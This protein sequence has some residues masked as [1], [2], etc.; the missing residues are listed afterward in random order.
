MR[1][2]TTLGTVLG[3]LIVLAFVGFLAAATQSGTHTGAPAA[4]VEATA[5]GTPA[6]TVEVA[7]PVPTPT[8]LGGPLSP[9]AL[10]E[11][12]RLPAGTTIVACE[13]T[14][15]TYPPGTFMSGWDF[16]T[17]PYVLADGHCARDPNATPRPTERVDWAEGHPPYW[18]F[19]IYNRTAAAV[20]T[21]RVQA[22]CSV[23]QLAAEEALTSGESAPSGVPTVGPI[24]WQTPPDYKGT[25]SV[26]VTAGGQVQVTLGE[27]AAA[28]LPPC[29]GQP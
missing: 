2:T 7:E 8:V 18:T 11:L 24:R 10:V 26:V 16:S 28:S 14:M 19:T 15:P 29:D 1:T 25:V 17:R 3:G 12:S 21:F 27:I 23:L 4:T 6:A 9:E 5:M 20:F 13:P 22:A